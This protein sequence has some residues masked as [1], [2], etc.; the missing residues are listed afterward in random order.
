[1][2]TNLT[3]NLVT[4][5][6]LKS[7]HLYLKKGEKMKHASILQFSHYCHK[8]NLNFR[9]KY[10]IKK[11]VFCELNIDIMYEIYC[12]MFGTFIGPYV[13]KISTN[14]FLTVF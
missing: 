11:K 3:T 12:A 4:S 1:M 13:C 7:Q 6:Y 2:R 5:S 8:I 9:A 14:K 10:T